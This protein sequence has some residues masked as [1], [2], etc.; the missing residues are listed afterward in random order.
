MSLPLL[1][2]AASS[3]VGSEDALS[4]C[5]LTKFNSKRSSSWDLSRGV[6]K[7]AHL[8][9]QGGW[10]AQESAGHLQAILRDQSR[11]G[12]HPVGGMLATQG[13]RN[14]KTSKASGRQRQEEATMGPGRPEMSQLLA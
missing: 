14:T 9:P 11:P 5:Q 12:G 13:G 8:A 3:Q 10:R 1:S 2:P 4:T 6:S 7:P